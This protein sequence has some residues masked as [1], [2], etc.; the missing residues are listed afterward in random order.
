LR[1]GENY[2]RIAGVVM[3]AD[4]DEDTKEIL[5]ELHGQC[6]LNPYDVRKTKKNLIC[7]LQL[8]RQIDDEVFKIAMDDPIVRA[9]VDYNGWNRGKLYPSLFEAVCGV[10]CAQ[11]TRFS[12]ISQMMGSMC[13]RVAPKVVVDGD[14]YAAFPTPWEILEAGEKTLKECGLGFRARRIYQMSEAWVKNRFDR[15]DIESLGR[16]ELKEKLIGLPGVGTYTANL[17]LN[18]A[19]PIRCK[20]SFEE[21]QTPHIDSFVVGLISTFYFGRREI[22]YEIARNFVIRQWGEQAETIIGM[23]TTDTEEWTKPL[24]LNL[25]VQSGAR[26]SYQKRKR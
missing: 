1:L 5:V 2:D 12:R 15:I 26:S 9:A 14:L 3:W 19:A 25:P 10:I 20:A 22:S 11:R 4:D 21:E 6:E 8:E 16:L 13:D 18:L 23:L 24:G 17:A 7:S